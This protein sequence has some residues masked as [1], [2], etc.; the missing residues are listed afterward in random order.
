MV[1][2]YL[3]L[4]GLQDLR[5]G[6][7]LSRRWYEAGFV[8][9]V[10]VGGQRAWIARRED[11]DWQGVEA[12]YLAK[13][14]DLTGAVAAELDREAS[15]AEAGGYGYGYGRN[16][17]GAGLEESGAEGGS[18]GG[19]AV[20]DDGDRAYLGDGVL[21]EEDVDLAGRIAR[22][23]GIEIRD[24]VG[25]GF[26]AKNDGDRMWC[27][28]EMEYKYRV[29]NVLVYGLP[30]VGLHYLDDLLWMKLFYPWLTGLLLVGWAIFGGGWPLVW[31]GISSALHLRLTGDLLTGGLILWAYLG[32]FY[33]VVEMLWRDDGWFGVD[34]SRGQPMLLAVFLLLLSGTW[35]RWLVYKNIKRLAGWGDLIVRGFGYW[36]G[37]WLLVSLI[38]GYFMGW[39]FGLGFGLILPGVGGLGGI[40]GLT[41]GVSSL[42]GVLGFGLF[43]L[44][45][46]EWV[47]QLVGADVGV[48][49]LEGMRV[50]VGGCFGLLM[51]WIYGKQWGGMKVK[52]DG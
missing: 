41:P 5:L 43:Y 29:A 20:G 10:D 1:K 30:V 46:G 34:G 50:E 28:A 26:E 18:T 6:G 3:I 40:N 15:R 11:W 7:E 16:K 52:N 19:K 31:N 36:A 8:N 9:E 37:A 45:G 2:T 21:T 27:R 4:D 48:D 24:R 44:F 47:G 13:G 14:G 23:Y 32:S 22:A 12:G 33:G 17:R 39:E 42:L 38:G 51:L 35:G 49:L 25:N